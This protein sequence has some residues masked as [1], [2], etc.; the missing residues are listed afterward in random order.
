MPLPSIGRYRLWGG[1]NRAKLNPLPSDLEPVFIDENGVYPAD[2]A[3]AFA[4]VKLAY[5]LST[6]R[7]PLPCRTENHRENSPVPLMNTGS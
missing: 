5:S 1:G 4:A 2:F 3:P 7:F 6:R